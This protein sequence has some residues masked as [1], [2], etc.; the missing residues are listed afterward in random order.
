MNYHFYNN[1]NNNY[2]TTV[3]F[4]YM[5]SFWNLRKQIFKSLLHQLFGTKMAKFLSF[6]VHVNTFTFLDY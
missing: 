3:R 4:I 5:N 6:F 2:H 1:N